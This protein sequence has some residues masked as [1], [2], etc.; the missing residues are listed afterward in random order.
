MVKKTHTLKNTVICD[1]R[2][3][4]FF[5]SATVWGGAWHDY[6]LLKNDFSPD[7]NWFKRLQVWLDSGY[8]GFKKDYVAKTVHQPQKKPR[9]SK[10]NPN[11]FLTEEQKKA[12]YNISKERIIIE[13]AIRGMKRYNVLVYPL[14]IKC[15]RFIE[16]IIGICAGLWNYKLNLSLA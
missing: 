16:R 11:P 13:H 14:R 15:E 12:N 5:L 10:S 7:Q 1:T 8:Q 9:K 4:I 3:F 2:R 6:S